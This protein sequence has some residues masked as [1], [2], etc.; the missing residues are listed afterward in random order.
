[1]GDEK[2]HF[3]QAAKDTISL[4]LTKPVITRLRARLEE[5]KKLSSAVHEKQ[6]KGKQAVW[7]TTPPKMFISALDGSIENGIGTITYNKL[8]MD[9]DKKKLNV[10]KSKHPYSDR[11]IEV[12]AE[13][14]VD[15]M[16]V[17]TIEKYKPIR[18][19]EVRE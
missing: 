16:I 3:G 7:H 15:C 14:P 4:A 6:M 17:E 10:T 11:E 9:G 2:V 1:M 5:L 13:Y 18:T 12:N 19:E 8:K